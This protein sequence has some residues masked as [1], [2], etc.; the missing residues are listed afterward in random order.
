MLVTVIGLY[1]EYDDWR[2]VFKNETIIISMT[3]ARAM[4]ITE[5]VCVYVCVVMF[6]AAGWR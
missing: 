5:Y 2:C 6:S 1:T 4:R 3:C